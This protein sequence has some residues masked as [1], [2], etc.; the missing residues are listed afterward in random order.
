M[1]RWFKWLGRGFTDRKVLGSNPTSASRFFLSM[2]EQPGSIPPLVFP[3]GGVAIRH[4]E[5]TLGTRAK[6][7]HAL[8]GRNASQSGSTI[9][10]STL[11]APS[12]RFRP[13]L[14]EHSVTTS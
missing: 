4:V 3:S 2:L 14:T 1:A 8:I 10:D 6:R 12:R 5:A 7:R 9:S 11:L 13:D